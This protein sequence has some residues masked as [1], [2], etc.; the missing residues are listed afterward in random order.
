MTMT[1]IRFTAVSASLK[2][3]KQFQVLHVTLRFDCLQ[4][5]YLTEGLVIGEERGSIYKQ[6]SRFQ[7]E[8][9]LQPQQCTA[10]RDTLTYYDISSERPH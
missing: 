4:T 3:R 5:Q 6:P 10:T 1:N 7:A 2:I 9:D 8:F